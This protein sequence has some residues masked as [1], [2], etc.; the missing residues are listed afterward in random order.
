MALLPEDSRSQQRVL[1]IALLVGAAV[2][3]YLYVY[4]P[5]R[6]EIAGLE[7]R[8][9]TLEQSNRLTRIRTGDLDRTRGELERAE[10]LLGALQELVPERAEV[11]TIYE[12]LA[13]RSDALGLELVSVAP[14]RT[15][16]AG[17]AYYRRQRWDMILEGRYHDL[18][19]FLAQVASLP[20]VVRPE[21][22]SIEG[23]ER[24]GGG[25]PVRAELTLETF[26]LAGEDGSEPPAGEE[27]G[28]G[29]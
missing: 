7:Q 24:T 9:E 23:L 12:A 27:D 22:R 29:T 26:V 4:L 14:S 6:E 20:R 19:R 3:F 1:G 11:A 8:V 28:D 2:L 16:D 21:V 17:E 18:G 25:Y 10:G 5:G 15:T 13:A